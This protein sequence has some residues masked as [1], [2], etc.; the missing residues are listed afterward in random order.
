VLAAPAGSLRTSGALLRSRSKNGR[1]RHTP[2]GRRP[3]P[4]RANFAA[5]HA[6]RFATNAG[7]P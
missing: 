6:R 5:A 2:G 7:R 4:K 1:R 3:T